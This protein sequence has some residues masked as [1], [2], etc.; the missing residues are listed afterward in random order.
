[1][2]PN[3][4]SVRLVVPISKNMLDIRLCIFIRMMFCFYDINICFPKLIIC[5]YVF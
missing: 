4:V 1:M 3:N 5:Y 2:L